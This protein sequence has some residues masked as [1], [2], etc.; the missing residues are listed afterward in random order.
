[1]TLPLLGFGL[2]V[3]LIPGGLA[4]L[5]AVIGVLVGGGLMYLI[6]V[7]GDAVYKKETMGGGDIKLA[8]AIGAFMGWRVLL[9]A[10]FASFLLGAIGGAAYMVLGG[11]EKTVPFGP[12]LAAGAL[13]ALVAGQDIW[14]WYMGFFG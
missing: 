3:S 12:F 7:V 6:A 10:L 1:V 5:G 4:P 9:V 2:A 11:R 13:I 14:S 8:A